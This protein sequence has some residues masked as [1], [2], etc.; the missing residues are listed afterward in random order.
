VNTEQE[1]SYS[2]GKRT[3]R[4]SIMGIMKRA[5]GGGGKTILR[6][7]GTNYMDLSEPSSS[8]NRGVLCLKGS[9]ICIIFF[10]NVVVVKDRER[11][12]GRATF[13][14]CFDVSSLHLPFLVSL[15]RRMK[16]PLLRCRIFILQTFTNTRLSSN[17]SEITRQVATKFC[18]SWKRK[19]IRLEVR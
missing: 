16:Y 7:S 3:T 17:S 15:L 10:D 13:D 8:G 6:G 2:H 9:C 4:T 14:V 18:C 19:P 11:E 1:C 12:K 5:G